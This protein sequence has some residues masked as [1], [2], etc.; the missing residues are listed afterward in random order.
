MN[1]LSRS[2]SVLKNTM[3][4][5]VQRVV[6]IGSGFLIQVMYIRFLGIEYAGV[7]SLFAAVLSVLSL[8]ELGIGAAITYNLYRPIADKDYSNIS[9]Y[10]RFYA[11]AYRAVAGVILLAGISITPF[12]TYIIKDTPNVKENVYIIYLLILTDTV[13]SY[14]LVYKSTLLIAAQKNRVVANIQ[15]V[16]CM[17]KCALFIIILTTFRNYYMILVSSAV[18]TVLQN[19]FISKYADKQFPE[20]KNYRGTLEKSETKSLFANVRAMALYK[21]SGV[22]L[23]SADN[24]I[25]SIKCGTSNVG[26]LSNYNLV[27]NN[28]YNL[29][30]QFY[31]SVSSSV[32]D[33]AT[34]NDEKK[35]YSIFQILNFISFWIYG[36]CSVLITLLVQPFIKLFF[37][38]EYLFGIAIVIVLVIDF[39]V[40]G[41]LGTIH[42]FRNAHGLFTQGRYRP[43]VMAVLNIILSLILFECIGI[44][45]IFLATILSRLMTQVWYDPWI[46]Y[47]MVFKKKIGRYFIEYAKEVL[48]LCFGGVVTYAMCLFIPINNLVLILFVRALVCTVIFNAIIVLLCRKLET[49]KITMRI[50][51]NLFGKVFRKQEE[52]NV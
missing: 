47:R 36:F 42:A 14:L 12:I 43:L 28:V 15:T 37:G 29:I 20:L 1:D 34:E 10:V 33:L 5:V 13:A 17:I 2:K 21:V 44:I 24:I 48:I 6:A 8:A 39:Y 3:A 19:L 23:S 16:A 7:S 40:K 32:G 35:E 41:M 18:V 50:V 9:A 30:S 4:G 52:E 27:I 49:F 31:A 45:G 11:K 25:L 26:I 38:K 22:V 46:V 51:K